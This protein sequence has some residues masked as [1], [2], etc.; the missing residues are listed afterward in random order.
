MITQLYERRQ[1]AFHAKN[2]FTPEECEFLHQRGHIITD[3]GMH[4]QYVVMDHSYAADKYTSLLEYDF[5]HDYKRRSR[6]SYR[7]H[8]VPQKVARRWRLVAVIPMAHRKMS[9]E[10]SSQEVL[11]G[12]DELIHLAVSKK[13]GRVVLNHHQLERTAPSWP[14]QGLSRSVGV[15]HTV[16]TSE[17]RFAGFRELMESQPRVAALVEASLHHRIGTER[18]E[19]LLKGYESLPPVAPKS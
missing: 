4:G 1:V 2:G 3:L 16:R 15:I 13:H 19:A 17:K 7:V 18:A 8:V 12:W 10:L 14:V 5:F 6:G 11:R 9:F